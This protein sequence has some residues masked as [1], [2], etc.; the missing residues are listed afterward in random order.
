MT[1]HGYAVTRGCN[2]Q[3]QQRREKLR[4]YAVTRSPIHM[5]AHVGV[6]ACAC[7][8]TC[9][10]ACGC[11]RVTVQ[12]ARR[13]E[14]VRVTRAR[15]RVTPPLFLFKKKKEEGIGHSLDQ[16]PGQTDGMAPLWSN[17]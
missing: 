10:R 15:N 16:Q 8:R 6:C 13:A 17:P 11:N 1:F 9:V 3:T 7:L 5:C 12:L 4:G 2:S 14:G